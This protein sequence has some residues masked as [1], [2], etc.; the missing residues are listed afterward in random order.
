MA[1]HN[2]PTSAITHNIKILSNNAKNIKT[3][4]EKIKAKNLVFE[5]N[6]EGMIYATYERG[7]KEMCV[8]G[9]KPLDIN[10]IKTLDFILI[11]ANKQHYPEIIY[12]ELEDYMEYR[13]ITSKDYAY[14]QLDKAIDIIKKIVVEEYKKTNK[15]HEWEN[16]FAFKKGRISYNRCF[17]YSTRIVRDVLCQ[18]YTIYP[19]WIG[20]LNKNAYNLATYIF[21]LAR[22]NLES[23][24]KNN[25]FTI[26]LKAVSDFLGLKPEYTKHHKQL[27]IEPIREAIMEINET[28]EEQIK[29]IKTLEDVKKI[30]RGNQDIK[31]YEVHLTE[32]EVNTKNYKQLLIDID[33]NIS[34]F[35]NGYLEIFLSPDIV[36]L[37]TPKAVKQN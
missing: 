19:H 5:M 26:S 15:S 1:K 3:V 16:E 24:T 8:F 7:N 29:E 11:Q 10:A 28:S 30:A 37:I 17:I 12:F 13:G 18:Y 35:L 6:E 32:E 36:E 4:D 22:Q 2:T 25:S 31:I 20:K 9:L 14:K 27:I 34:L 21:Y 23:L 33:N